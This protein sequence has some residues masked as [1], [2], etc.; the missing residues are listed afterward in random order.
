MKKLVRAC[1]LFA[2]CAAGLVGMGHPA[3]GG[4]LDGLSIE[5][6]A[7]LGEN[8]AVLC[9]DWN[10][11]DSPTLVFGYRW[12]DGQTRTGGDMLKAVE[13]ASDRFYL[14]LQSSTYGDLVDGIGWD[15]DGNGFSKTDPA[16]YFRPGWVDPDYW[17]YTTSADGITWEYSMVGMQGRELSSGSWDG[18]A[19]GSTEAPPDLVPEPATLMLVGWGCIWMAAR[20]RRQA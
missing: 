1:F 17:G 7:G 14:E 19:Y 20:R 6:W 2:V 5:Y 4:P 10:I 11:G 15:A 3:L 12:P 18:W 16:D 9:I 13:S 8:E